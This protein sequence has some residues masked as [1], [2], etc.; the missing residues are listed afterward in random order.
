VS[1]RGADV[2]FLLPDPP[3][4][5]T[6]SPA[7][8]WARAGFAEAGV[9]PGGD[10]PDLAVVT[11]ADAPRDS[12]ARSVV[13]VGRGGRRA[14][15]GQRPHVRRFAA[16]P[17]PDAPHLIIPVDRPRVA[18]YAIDTWTASESRLRRRRNQ[19][20]AALVA[21]GA[22]PDLG[23]SLTVGTHDARPPF[24]VAAAEQLG[25]DPRAD[26]FLTLGLGDALT[27][28]VFQLFEPRAAAPRWVLKFARV[29]GYTDP[30]DR[31]E[32]GLRLAAEAGA[33]VARHAPR[34]LGRLE[35]AGLH[36][37]LE[38]AAPGRRLTFML[39]TPG[40]HPAKLRAIDAVAA[41]I[42]EIGR[43]TAAPPERLGEE[44]RRLATE[45]VP[46]W[47]EAG[48]DGDPLARLPELPAVLAHHDLG[49]WNLIVDGGRFT[50][51]DW[52]S[53]RAH[54][55]P[56]WD[57][58]YFLVDALVHLAGAWGERDREREAARL[59]L[60]SAPA[61]ALLF[62]WIQTAVSVLGIPHS[63]V[64]AIVTLGWMHHGLSAGA[65]AARL[66]SVM[67]GAGAPGTYGEWMARVW[68]TTPGL[69]LGWKAWAQ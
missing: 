16:L 43:E 2:R 66:A 49:C 4:S 69:G 10:R 8:P 63:A 50:A 39:Q 62:R 20:A 52:E 31:D 3:A 59:L 35:V 6:C 14:L 11:A 55:L 22:F 36:A 24:M 58:V 9:K 67:G 23:R 41:W 17:G 40:G 19:T 34:L 53:A 44:R 30:F 48:L 28:L 21:V 27:R 42:V 37:S 47:R 46:A 7:L 61:S 64:G 65:R 15:R 56:L 25:A 60:G 51:V 45:V 1:L 54:A 18:R 13:V 33:A 57:L 26:W 32:R 29:P 12:A 5:V 68:L 38:G